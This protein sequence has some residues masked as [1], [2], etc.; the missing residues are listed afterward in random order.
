L[1]ALRSEPFDPTPAK[2]VGG[3]LVRAHFTAPEALGATLLLLGTELA[4]RIAKASGGSPP[5]DR[6]IQTLGCL[7]TGY[8][9]ALRERTFDEQEVIK[10]AM[11]LA[12]DMA[13]RRLRDSEARFLAVFDSAAMA[14]V[15]C[16]FDGVILES[17]RAL[18]DLLGYTH[19]ELDAL[20]GR[21]IVHP[22]D[23][24]E[25]VR[26]CGVLYRGEAASFR[27]RRRL[28]K[29]DG[30]VLWGDVT[31]SAV[32]D[33]EGMPVYQVAMIEDATALH[34]ANQAMATLGMQDPLTGLPTRAAFMARLDSLIGR[35]DHP[36]RVALCVFGM[37]GFAMITDGLGPEVGDDVLLKIGTKL[38]WH[39]EDNGMVAARLGGDEFALLVPESEGTR[40]V[41]PLVEEAMRLISEPITVHGHRLSVQ[42]SVGIVERAVGGEL[43]A[44]LLKD[45]TMALHWAKLGGKAQWQLFDGQRSEHDSAEL[46]LALTLPIALENEEFVVQYQPVYGLANNELL[47]VEALLRWDHPERGMLGTDAFMSL[48]ERTGLVVRLADWTLRQVCATAKRWLDEFGDRAPVVSLRLPTRQARDPDFLPN[49]LQVLSDSG[50]PATLLQLDLPSEAVSTEL[51]AHAEDVEML[52]E[53]GIRFSVD[54]FEGHDP[55][56]VNTMPL[57]MLKSK[58]LVVQSSLGERDPIRVTVAW[59]LVSLAHQMDMVVVAEGVSASDDLDWLREIGVDGAQGD[60][61]GGPR[62]AEEIEE[63]FRR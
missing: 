40:T 54:G 53:R 11:W 18:Q 22:D 28:L 33:V 63:L 61:L 20:N 39:A 42:S 48:A 4:G 30:D 3:S 35:V 1:A 21:Q 43:P 49:V 6:V 44:Q 5:A 26:R 27:L 8:A 31:V 13:Q 62:P 47:F 23:L 15:I 32:R 59:N 7:S 37:D 52:T 60:L 58:R 9:E 51:D 36:T 10:Q 17:N 38:R 56:F 45:A 46:E 12:T 41:T 2:E 57:H 19:D 14:L 16:D 29:K 55:G 24:D 25:L 34:F 50:L